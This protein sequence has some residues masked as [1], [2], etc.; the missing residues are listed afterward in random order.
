MELIWKILHKSTDR[1]SRK[2]GTRVGKTILLFVIMKIKHLLKW[3]IL[4][5]A[6][7]V[8]F[9]TQSFYG[10]KSSQITYDVKTTSYTTVKEGTKLTLYD[11]MNSMVY[12]DKKRFI[13]NYEESGEFSIQVQTLEA[14]TLGGKPLN[15][16]PVQTVLVN[17][18][19]TSSDGGPVSPFDKGEFDQLAA[20]AK[21]MATKVSNCASTVAEI[22]AWAAEL[23]K[24]GAIEKKVKNLNYFI[25]G[26]ETIVLDLTKGVLVS[27]STKVNGQFN[28]DVYYEYAYAGGDTCPVLKK[29]TYR[30]RTGLPSGVPGTE[31][32]I[33][34]LSNVTVSNRG[35]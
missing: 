24:A 9:F 20:T 31:V 6:A 11:Q 26:G 33:H 21:D 35:K 30:K 5:I 34:E 25:Q 19:G 32:T 14:P 1:D 10:G 17:R 29:I 22:N 23:R 28:N 7:V 27:E 2:T 13:A 16:Q 8:F 3:A 12:T 18:N 15:L 4:P